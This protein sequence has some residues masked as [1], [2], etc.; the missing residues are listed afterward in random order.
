M[1]KECYQATLASGKNHT[2]VI[3]E[4][5]P[6]PEP[7]K[8]P[9]KVEIVPGD[10]TKVLKIKT[11][12]PTSEKEKMVSFLQVNQDV[13]TWKHKDIPEID[14]KIIQH[15]LNV[16]SKYKPVQQKR[17]IF[18]PKHNKAITEKI[19]KL[20]E[21]GLI[22]EVFYPDWLANVVMVK[23]N[24]GKRRMC[25]DF[26]DLNKAYPKYSFSLPRID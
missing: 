4:P 20:L 6:I 8:I 1:A 5:E 21:A 17:R 18:A 9:Q 13:F 22:R 24:N 16:N 23:K 7:S 2:W 15:R 14:R 10:S 11:T 25:V 3:N 26:I 19:E 12:L